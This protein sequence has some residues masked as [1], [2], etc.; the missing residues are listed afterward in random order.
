MAD[1]IVSEMT[2]GDMYERFYRRY[3]PKSEDL[4]DRI[5]YL[6]S[7][8]M[9]REYHFVCHTMDDYVVGDLGLQQSP[10]KAEEDV[11]WL[12][13]VSVDT[14]YRQR[15]IA[16]RLLEASIRHAHEARKV[17]QLSSYSEDGKL[18]LKPLIAR[19]RK[20]FP[21]VSITS[22]DPYEAESVAPM[23]MR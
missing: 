10:Y 7:S 6:H 15:G 8:E 4:F 14:N 1:L 2:G 19:L 9:F 20:E 17:L 5:R 11:L 21:V 18:Y 13:H 23:R 3:L 16:T 22:S 12:K